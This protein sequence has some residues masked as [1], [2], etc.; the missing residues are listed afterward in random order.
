MTNVSQGANAYF[1]RSVLE[2]ADDDVFLKVK[3][4]NMMFSGSFGG[5]FRDSEGRYRGRR[6]LR[7]RTAVSIAHW[8]TKAYSPILHLALSILAVQTVS[9]RRLTVSP[10]CSRTN[11][12]TVSAILSCK[13]RKEGRRKFWRCLMWFQCGIHLSGRVGD[14]GTGGISAL[15]P[16]LQFMS[17][18][19][20]FSFSFCTARGLGSDSCSNFTS[21]YCW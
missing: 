14:N 4:W 18:L 7:K 9:C 10:L 21:W 19:S 17:V 12:H 6:N 13:W 5:R 1:W 2:H 20:S 11:V 16:P 3:M 8:L 15:S